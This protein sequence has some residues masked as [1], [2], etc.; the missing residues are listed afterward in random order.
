VS[1]LRISVRSRPNPSKSAATGLL[2]R[3][4]GGRCCWTPATWCSLT[5]TN[6]SPS[7]PWLTRL[8]CGPLP[9]R[10]PL[11]VF[12]GTDESPSWLGLLG[13]VVSERNPPSISIP[14]RSQSRPFDPA[15]LMLDPVR[16]VDRVGPRPLDLVGPAVDVRDGGRGRAGGGRREGPGER[17]SRS[18]AAHTEPLPPT[19]GS[20]Q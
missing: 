3:R 1:S 16:P 6:W 14:S 11:W 9:V 12:I 15:D 18:H 13:C 17:A 19:T 7:D 4:D 5:P 20:R 10:W 2:T 8:G